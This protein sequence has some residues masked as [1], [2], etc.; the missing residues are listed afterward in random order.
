MFPIEAA[1]EGG[2]CKCRLTPC[3]GENI[4]IVDRVH[5]TCVDSAG[6]EGDFC[7][8]DDDCGGDQ[9]LHCEQSKC[10]KP[11]HTHDPCNFNVGCADGFQCSCGDFNCATHECLAD[12]DTPCVDDSDCAN[13]SCDTFGDSRCN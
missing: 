5:C 6:N 11:N 3:A 13:G 2:L 4:Q 10:A 1:C 9:T 12:T 7:N 8:D